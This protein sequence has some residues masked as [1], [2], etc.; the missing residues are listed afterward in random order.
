[1]VGF[2]MVF[3][4][5]KGVIK[6]ST[7]T[8]ILY[9][10][11]YGWYRSLLLKLS[12]VLFAK[13]RYKRILGRS[14]D[15]GSPKTFDEKLLWLMLYWQHPLKA[16]CGDKYT[17][18]KYVQHQGWGHVLTKL[19]GVYENSSEIDFDILPNKFVLKCTHGCGYNIIC[20][21]KAALDQRESKRKLDM[22]MET[23]VSKIAGELHYDS[24]KP[25]IICEEYLDDLTGK[26]P[27]DYKV[28]CFGGKAYCT[29]VCQERTL[30]NDQAIFDIY[31]REWKNKLPYSKSSLQANRKI[32]K[33]DAYDEIIEAAE[34]LSKPFPFVRMDF[35]CIRGRV[36]LGEMTFTPM[37]CIDPDYTDIAEQVLGS[38]IVLPPPLPRRRKFVRETIK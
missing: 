14:P 29:L 15:F 16:E 19:L 18:R 31:D 13:H 6:Q 8:M 33:P 17:M 23:N 10:E 5:I 28:Y 3:S 20:N 2:F 32:P 12:P 4:R 22:W 30:L 37:G 27:I 9:R 21:D 36:I 11:A 38:L 34:A 7:N 26:V 1:M 25:R 35:Y 24:M